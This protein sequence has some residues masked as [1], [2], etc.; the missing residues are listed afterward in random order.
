MGLLT[1]EE[2]MNMKT[3]KF[4][5]KRKK[6]KE[7][8]YEEQFITKTR[9]HPWQTK[10]GKSIVKGAKVRGKKAWNYLM[11]TELAYRQGVGKKR[12]KKTSKKKKK[13]TSRKK[14]R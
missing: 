9:L 1:K 2:R 7:L 12:R 3:G 13:K 4:E 11:D 6:I 10:Q 14:K 5:P 8:T